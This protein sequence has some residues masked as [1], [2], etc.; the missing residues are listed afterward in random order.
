MYA[1]RKLPLLSV[2]TANP[3]DYADVYTT[4]H[5]GMEP[6]EQGC[7]ALLFGPFSSFLPCAV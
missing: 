4:R 6:K 3:V 7:V 2:A 5:I 1:L